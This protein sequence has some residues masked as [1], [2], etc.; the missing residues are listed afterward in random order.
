M[1]NAAGQPVPAVASAAP[2]PAGFWIA[3]ILIG[4]TLAYVPAMRGGFL[5]DDNAYVVD[6]P[7]LRESGGLWRIWFEPGATPQYYPLTFT[8]F[9]I[10]TSLFGLDPR[11]YHVVNIL[12]HATSAILLGFALRRLGLRAAWPAA[13]LFALHPVQ[14]ESVAW[15]T[16]RKNT[17]CGVFYFAAA[18]AWLGGRIRPGLARNLLASGLFI[19]ALLSKTTACT[20]PA[21]L[22]LAVWYRDGS[23]GRRDLLSLL[24][25]FALALAAGGAT[26]WVEQRHVGAERVDLGLSAADRLVLAGQVPWFY[27]GQLLWPASLSFIYPRWTVSAAQPAQWLGLAAAAL[28]LAALTGAQ[29]RIGRGPLAAALYFGG[30]LLPVSGLFNVFYMQYAWTADHFV[31]LAAAGPMALACEALA[32]LIGAPPS[33]R[34]S[35]NSTSPSRETSALPPSASSTGIARGALLLLPALA[36]APLTW[37]QSG[38]YRDLET[39]WL[40]VLAR[41]RSAWIAYNNLGNLYRITGRPEEAVAALQNA[42]DLRPVSPEP[43]SNLGAAMIAA[44][45]VGEGIAACRRAL[46]LSPD[47]AA[48]HQ[49]LA[50]GLERAGEF[51]EALDHYRTALRLRPDAPGAAEALASLDVAHGDV[52]EAVA[53]LVDV[54]RRRP[55]DAGVLNNLGVAFGRA[56]AP[57]QAVA[58]FERATS[59]APDQA[60]LWANL[61]RALAQD[62]K[63]ERAKVAQDRAAKLDPRWEGAELWRPAP[64]SSS[65]PSSAA[66]ETSEP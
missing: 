38:I 63:P 32:R 17:L 15:I 16:E 6:N 1:V 47:Y 54:A 53:L 55:D 21:A 25:W 64:A 19:A 13:L 3:M 22:L 23:I 46:E 43:L 33:E 9:W 65:A 7:V 52:R 56:D 11:G 14:A 44:G 39:L 41:N 49:N 29:R 24:P 35:V 61:A 40:D 2:S 28:L 60:I 58:V 8:T 42:A 20:L 50:A 27:L 62:G 5:W 12:L 45:R 66:S 30:T 36:C 57:A 26:W 51:P 31:Y 48:A 10:E 34:T 4:V 37:R 18:I 59:L